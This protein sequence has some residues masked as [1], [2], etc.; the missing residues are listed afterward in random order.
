MKNL[1]EITILF[2][3]GIYFVNSQE[4]ED[5]RIVGGY[6]I[7]IKDAQYQVSLRKG[8]GHIC[9]GAIISETHVLTAAHCTTGSS[10]SQ[11]SVRI[12]S[13]FRISGGEIVTV[14]RIFQHPLY[15]SK[16]QDYD[17]S[18]LL[19]SKKIKFS[20]TK[21]KIAL[22]T[23]NEVFADGSPTFIT[24]WGT[25]SFGG[26]SPISLRA[27]VVNIV[28]QDKCNQAYGGGITLSMICAAAKGKDSCQGSVKK[29]PN[30]IFFLKYSH[31]CSD[32]GGPLKSQNNKLIGVV[33]F[34]I[35]CALDAYP[36]VYGRVTYVRD[37]IRSVSGV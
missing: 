19:L 11:L 25:T 14:S 8:T 16:T 13:K 21:A 26:G 31:Y 35:G 7:D 30:I 32:S 12:G 27:A 36:G 1:I 18:V 37:W 28:S 17:F 20:P 22:P 5:D 23:S 9:G 3:F 29:I 33:S 24:G 10:A 6:V 15:N 34:G 2:L 4:I